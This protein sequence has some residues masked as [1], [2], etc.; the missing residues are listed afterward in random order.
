MEEQ[1]VRDGSAVYLVEPEIATADDV[2]PGYKRTEVGV[3][4]EDWCVHRLGNLGEFKN[5]I[6]KGK[7]DFGHG[8]A[9]VNLMDVFG[10]PKISRSPELGLVKSSPSEREAYDL[11]AGDVLFVRSSVKPEGVG[12]TTLVPF[13]LA[14]TVFSGFLIRFRSNSQLDIGFKEHCFWE[15]G[16][17]RRL[18]AGSTVSANTNVNQEALKALPLAFPPNT[19][20]QRAIATALSDAD[21]LIASLNRLIAKKRAIKQAAMQQL[22]TGQTRLPGFTGEWETKRLGDLLDRV[23][24]GGTPSRSNPSFWNGDIPWVTV[25][26]FASF[27]SSATQEYVTNEGLSNSATNLIPAGTV[28]TST[29]MALGK[30][31]MYDL[32]VTIN[33]DL[34]ALFCGKELSSLYLYFWFE[35]HSELIEGLGSGSTVKGLSTSDLKSIQFLCPSREE[36]TAI[37]TVLSDMDTEIEALERRRDKARQIKQGMMQQ[38][39]TGR[40]RLVTP[41][42]AA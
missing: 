10:V 5:G 4:P 26:D 30:A 15:R 9:F 23:I 37:A 34:K 39:L 7:Q 35:N 8:Y 36:Q 16:F 3:I 13:D 19:Q 6:N 11:K 12:L 25:K 31:V 17:R 1:A 38:L 28:I 18:I 42:V 40:V 32:D 27:N 33:Q 22:L 21:A 41:G 2:P 14:D 20:E 24:G 29:R